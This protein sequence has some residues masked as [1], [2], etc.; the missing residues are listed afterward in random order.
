[1]PEKVGDIV[2]EAIKE[3]VFY[4]LTDTKLYYR[5]MIQT[6]NEEI[7]EAYKQNKQIHKLLEKNS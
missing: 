2:F 1:M 7:M 4:I 6:R 5:R 3:N